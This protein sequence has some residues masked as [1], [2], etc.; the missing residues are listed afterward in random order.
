MDAV[1]GGVFAVAVPVVQ[2]VDVVLVHYGVVSAAWTMSMPMRFGVAV[3]RK[4]SHNRIP[5]LSVV[6]GRG[7]CP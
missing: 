5:S 4:H 2:I 3:R 1:L 7:C 6:D